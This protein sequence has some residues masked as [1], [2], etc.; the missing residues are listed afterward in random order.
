M[1]LFDLMM[2]ADHQIA[3]ELG[4]AI[5]IGNLKYPGEQKLP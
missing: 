4:S 5:E 2:I 1:N 3:K